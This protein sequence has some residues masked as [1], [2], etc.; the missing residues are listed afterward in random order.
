MSRSRSG[1]SLHPGLPCGNILLFFP[2]RQQ[3]AGSER[4]QLRQ[5]GGPLELPVLQV[6]ASST[7]LIINTLVLKTPA[8]P[9]ENSDI[10]QTLKAQIK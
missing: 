9:I 8:T 7:I 3:G 1:Q 10:I 4:E 6:T 2:D 5:E